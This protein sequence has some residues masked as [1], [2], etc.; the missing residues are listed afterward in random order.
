MVK[1]FKVVGIGNA[2]V[3]V[4][5]QVDEAFLIEN[6]IQKNIMQLIGLRESPYMWAR[7]GFKPKANTVLNRSSP[8]RIKFR[9]I[10]HAA[11]RLGSSSWPLWY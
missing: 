1:T 6:K 5:M 4:L 8:T 11:F 9:S 2:M 10:S 7:S 3:D